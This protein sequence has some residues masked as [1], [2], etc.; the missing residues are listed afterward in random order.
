MERLKSKQMNCFR[1][2]MAEL[3]FERRDIEMQV[4]CGK[5]PFRGGEVYRS[6]AQGERSVC[7]PW[8]ACE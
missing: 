7:V 6:D 1:K 2:K 5:V 4:N 8:R 3:C